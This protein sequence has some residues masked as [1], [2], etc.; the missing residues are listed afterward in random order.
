M[1]A[2]T[3]ADIRF[4][5]WNFMWFLMAIL[6]AGV[7][8]TVYADTQPLMTIQLGSVTGSC[9]GGTIGTGYGSFNVDT[10][11]SS[12]PLFGQCA[13][14]GGLTG[15]GG[16]VIAL[17]TSAATASL[18]LG[19]AYVSFIADESVSTTPAPADRCMQPYGHTESECDFRLA[20]PCVITVSAS[21]SMSAPSWLA[22]SPSDVSPI[23]CHICPWQTSGTLSHVTPGYLF[24]NCAEVGQFCYC[25]S[26]APWTDTFQAFA[27]AG[28]YNFYAASQAGYS[29]RGCTAS[30]DPTPSGVATAHAEV[31]ASFERCLAI[32][33]QP[34]ASLSACTGNVAVLGVD[35][36][37]A[38]AAGPICIAGNGFSP[39]TS[40]GL[41]Y[42]LAPTAIPALPSPP[43][44]LPPVESSSIFP[45]AAA[46]SPPISKSISA[47]LSPTTAPAPPLAELFSQAADARPP[48]EINQRAGRSPVFSRQEPEVH[49]T[50]ADALP[51][52]RDRP[53]LRP[54][55]ALSPRPSSCMAGTAALT[56]RGFLA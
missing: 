8:V 56:R 52:P 36:A 4:N 23:T 7:F 1:N 15:E 21:S 37:G 53:G 48:R 30:H 29:V 9:W 46:H 51:S 49:G 11:S 47:A 16:A 28:S 10:A 2:I 43:P 13:A 54:S 14:G 32:T 34:P 55:I 26:H 41:M 31:T 25:N 33:R 18:S 50:I 17:S 39:L 27:E 22:G 20:A 45:Q 24:G 42:I 44:T 3:S 6:M 12:F 38:Q 40:F 19:P 35:A 5:R